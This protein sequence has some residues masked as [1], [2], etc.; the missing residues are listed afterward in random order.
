MKSWI[1]FLTEN[2]GSNA[3]LMARMCNY[4]GTPPSTYFGIVE[5]PHR[6]RV[7]LGCYIAYCMDENEKMEEAKTKAE[8]E[9]KERD[10]NLTKYRNKL[11]KKPV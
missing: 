9:A 8:K 10:K 6:I 1:R 5:L 4:F 2:K 7:D 11:N 3:V